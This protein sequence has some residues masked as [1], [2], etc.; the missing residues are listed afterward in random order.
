M[1]SGLLGKIRNKKLLFIGILIG[2]F[3]LIG[4]SVFLAIHFSNHDHSYG[5]ST[6]FTC[7]DYP[8]ACTGVS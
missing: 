2:I 5:T 1:S 3:I 6:V 7:A 8:E 4:M